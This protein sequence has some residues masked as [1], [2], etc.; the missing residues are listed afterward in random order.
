M[1]LLL[2]GALVAWGLLLA[3]VVALCRAAAYGDLAVAAALRPRACEAR[4][5]RAWRRALTRVH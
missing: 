5:R 2:I 3:L 4:R 1:G